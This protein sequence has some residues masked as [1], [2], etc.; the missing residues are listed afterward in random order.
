MEDLFKLIGELKGVFGG[1]AA[2]GI[3]IAVWLWRERNQRDKSDADASGQ[4]QALGV[5]QEL[6]KNERDAKHLA[7]QRADQFAKERNEAYQQVWELKGQLKAITDQL[8][9]QTRELVELRSQL[10]AFKEQIDAKQ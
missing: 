4:I 7:E 2:I 3:S 9:G 10:R 5:Y 1:A 6:L 8:E